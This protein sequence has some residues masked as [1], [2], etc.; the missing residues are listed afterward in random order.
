MRLVERKPRERSTD[1]YGTEIGGDRR[2]YQV[3]KVSA[4]SNTFLN[5]ILIGG[6]AVR[7]VFA[8]T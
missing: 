6:G 2:Q 5:R 1:E 4:N 7:I 3:V 8:M